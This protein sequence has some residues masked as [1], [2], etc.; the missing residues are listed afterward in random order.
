[1]TDKHDR[2]EVVLGDLGNAQVKWTA[3]GSYLF[4]ARLIA[5]ND[6]NLFENEMGLFTEFYNN[7]KDVPQY[8]VDRLSE[9]IVACDTVSAI[10]KAGKNV[11]EQEEQDNV[12]AFKNLY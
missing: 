10:L 1:M 6:V 8:A 5:Q 9:G 7:Y 11:Y 4:N 2:V 3:A 12:H